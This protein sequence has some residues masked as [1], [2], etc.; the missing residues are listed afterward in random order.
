[1]DQELFEKFQARNFGGSS[2]GDW[3]LELKVKFAAKE[4]FWTVLIEL[5]RNAGKKLSLSL[6]FQHG[7]NLYLISA[8]QTKIINEMYD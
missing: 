2:K 5:L 3:K 6:K 7:Q 8:A 4:K 1:M